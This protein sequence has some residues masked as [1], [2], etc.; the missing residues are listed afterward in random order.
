VDVLK[1]SSARVSA[2]V[3][4]QVA[5]MSDEIVATAGGAVAAGL[6][7]AAYWFFTQG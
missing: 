7:Y 2:M 3:P 6:G 1:G 4:P 5:E